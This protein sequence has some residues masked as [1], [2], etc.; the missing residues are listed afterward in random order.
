MTDQVTLDPTPIPV[1]VAIVRH[2]GRILVTQR[3]GGT[4]LEGTWEFPGGK[5]EVGE[6]PAQAAVRECKEECG[7]EVQVEEAPWRVV[8]HRYPEKLVQLHFLFATCA[9][10]TVTHLQ[11]VD[12][13]WLNLDELREEDFP[14]ANRA[15]IQALRHSA[16]P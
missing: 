8:S 10:P 16:T 14:P 13:R 4:H 15:I 11:V 6:E 9:D 1:A 3:P 2:G 12:H 7:L 5:M